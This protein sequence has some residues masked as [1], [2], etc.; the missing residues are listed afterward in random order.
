MRIPTL[1]VSLCFA[2]VVAACGGAPTA[3]ATPAA[4]V[5]GATP[6]APV[7]GATPAASGAAVSWKDLSPAAKLNHMKTVV[8]PTMAKTFQAHDAAEFK[9]FDCKTCHGPDKKAP[10]Q[11]LP[12]LTF[13]GGKFT[14]MA[15][16]PELT[17]FMMEHVVPTMAKAMG[18]QPFDPA[19]HQGFG[20]G[21][22]HTVE[23]K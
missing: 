12:K 1:S 2:A 3:P 10:K 20:C 13:E 23:M 17:K 6:A 16:K 14:S 22:C 15:T 5:P 8:A 7:P 11:F 21:G 18:M 19:T 4:P 9:D